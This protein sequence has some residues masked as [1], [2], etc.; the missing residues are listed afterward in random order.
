MKRKLSFV[1][2]LLI[3]ISACKQN[4]LKVDL[5]DVHIDFEFY[6]FSDDLFAAS[7]NFES[8]L[9]ELQAK[10]PDI[11]PLFT[12][13]I[14]TIGL[15]ED[16][17]ISGLLNS[18][19]NDTLIREVKNK[20]DEII[21]TEQLKSDLEEAFRYYHYYFPNRIIPKVFTCVSGFNQSI[22]MTDSILGIGVDKYLGRDCDYYPRLGIPQYLRLNMNPDKI[23]PDAMYA[24]GITEFPFVGYGPHLVD[25][26]I[27]EG[28]ML[29]LLDAL[30]PDT[31]DSLKIG[32]TSEQM[33]F[34]RVKEN[35]MWTYLAEYKMLFSTE[36]MDVK[37]YVEDAPYTSSFTDQSPGRTG[38]WLGWQI[39]RAYM[40][41]HPET[42]LQELMDYKDCKDLLNKSGYQPD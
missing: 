31:A 3:I 30:L 36:R 6:N 38:A 28:K 41:K 5:S 13:D 29:Y 8:K 15:P 16:E 21:P 14:I 22:V 2:V 32:Y 20:V 12:A 11:L 26:M 37:R 18:F 27:Y 39:V 23:V 19:V 7:G 9:P 34:C 4:P 24:W 35:A 10:Y 33:D 40:K 25:R 42:S 17:N 1:L